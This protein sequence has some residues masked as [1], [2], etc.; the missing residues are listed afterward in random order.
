MSVEDSLGAL[1]LGIPDNDGL[2]YVGKVGTGFS[3]SDRQATCSHDLEPLATPDQTRSSPG[4]PAADD[5]DGTLRAARRWWE[6]SSSAN[7]R[8]AGGCANRRGE[9][10]APTRRPDE[11]VV[12]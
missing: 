5:G 9:D 12:E 11:V 10:C 3:A 6:R 4:S 7:G 1:L 8:R 2:R